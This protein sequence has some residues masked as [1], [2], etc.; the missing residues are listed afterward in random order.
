MM[1]LPLIPLNL[2]T[3]SSN[4]LIDLC[5]DSVDFGG[6]CERY[7]GTMGGEVGGATGRALEPPTGDHDR[8][9]AFLD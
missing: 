7:T 8:D 6:F 1:L 9:R 5:S 4:I 3:H 2:F